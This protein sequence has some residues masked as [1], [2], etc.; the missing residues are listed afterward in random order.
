MGVTQRRRHR[1]PV[2][3]VTEGTETNDQEPLAH[4]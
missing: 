4:L 3:H 1:Y 2:D